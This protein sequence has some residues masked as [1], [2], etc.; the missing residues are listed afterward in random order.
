M[1]DPD[2]IILVYNAESG[3]FNTVHS[4]L[5]KAF[6]GECGDCQLCH[7]TYGLTGMRRPWR[8]LIE[9]LPCPAVFLYRADFQK[10]YPDFETTFPAILAEYTGQLKHLVSADELAELENL[11][12]LVEFTSDRIYG[13]DVESLMEK[14]SGD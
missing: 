1:N 6:S 11:T 4:W 10:T 7:F 5:H 3:V 2:R 13:T 8:E 12:E 14:E 9:S